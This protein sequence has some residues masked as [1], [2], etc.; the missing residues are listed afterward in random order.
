MDFAL[1]EEQ[2]AFKEAA[3]AFAA[4]EMAPHAESWDRNCT[5]PVETL[6]AAAGLGFGGIYVREDVGG[7]LAPVLGHVEAGELE[8]DGA[9][10][11]L[12]L[13]RGAAEFY[14]AVR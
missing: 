12:D 4:G 13:A 14:C 8:D 7:Y 1:S 3:S 2:Q 5:F 11:V 9:V 6:R 10:R